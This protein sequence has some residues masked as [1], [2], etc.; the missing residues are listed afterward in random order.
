MPQIPLTMLRF[1]RHLSQNFYSKT[2]QMQQCGQ[3]LESLGFEVF[4]FAVSFSTWS[5]QCVI[6][7][8]IVTIAYWQNLPKILLCHNTERWGGLLQFHPNSKSFCKGSAYK[9]PFTVIWFAAVVPCPKDSNRTCL[10]SCLVSHSAEWGSLRDPYGIPWST[11]P[12]SQL[13]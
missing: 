11:H 3:N 4:W 2:W 6:E 10:H 8:I 5:P 1:W 7:Q 9:A 13:Y 12:L